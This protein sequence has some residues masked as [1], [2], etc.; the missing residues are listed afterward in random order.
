[1]KKRKKLNFFI[2]DECSFISTSQFQFINLRLQKLKD[3]VLPFGGLSLILAG[4]F[5]Q[6]SPLFGN[7]LWS[8]PESLSEFD[9]K[10]ARL[11]SLFKFTFLRNNVRQSND[12]RF[13]NLLNNL[14]LKQVTREDVDLLN[15][16]ILSSLDE[17][18]QAKFSTATCI[19]ATNAEVDNYNNKKLLLVGNKIVNI[20]SVQRPKTPHLIRIC[21]YYCV[22]GLVYC[23]LGTYIWKEIS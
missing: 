11:L 3:N 9:S 2:L 14:R 4:D 17:E 15:S 12:L 20:P 1:L 22:R 6:L 18:K 23:L 10:G 8:D 16:R 21:L 13:Q 19:F 5:Y 7:P